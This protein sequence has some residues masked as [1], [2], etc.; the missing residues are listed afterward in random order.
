M[1]ASR[2]RLW[3]VLHVVNAVRSPSYCPTIGEGRCSA[4]TGYVER[5]NAVTVRAQTERG[6]AFI[7][8]R[9]HPV[10]TVGIADAAYACFHIDFPWCAAIDI[11]KVKSHDKTIVKSFDRQTGMVA[12]V[13]V[14][15]IFFII[16]G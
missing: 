4:G 8:V 6:C 5:E 15:D 16:E 10:N 13:Y 2:P 12:V 11:G 9:S 1:L 7:A 3:V 14:Q